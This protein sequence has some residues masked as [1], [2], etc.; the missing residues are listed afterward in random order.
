[1]LAFAFLVNGNSA[2]DYVH[3]TV[4]GNMM[5]ALARYNG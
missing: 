2:T 5:A 4:E 1:M 3:N